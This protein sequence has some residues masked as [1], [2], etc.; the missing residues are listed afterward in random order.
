M[1]AWKK[2]LLNIYYKETNSEALVKETSKPY[3]DK[4]IQFLN[5]QKLIKDKKEGSYELTT[6][7][8]REAVELERHC[9]REKTMKTSNK[10][11]FGYS[12]LFAILTFGL[13]IT[14]GF[15]PIFKDIW[16]HNITLAIWIDI[17][18][19]II[20]ISIISRAGRKKLNHLT[21]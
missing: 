18:A 6:E 7:G 4:I 3:D 10:V 21:D 13:I 20:C 1:Q 15:Y 14:T 17:I 19:L 2:I 12:I 8:F 5:N 9:E 16:P 11:Q